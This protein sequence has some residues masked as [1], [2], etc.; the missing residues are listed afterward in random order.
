VLQQ[1][2]SSRSRL[3]WVSLS[4]TSGLRFVFPINAHRHAIMNQ[5]EAH[6]HSGC[7]VRFRP[8]LSPRPSLRS[9][10]IHTAGMHLRIT[11]LWDI[12]YLPVTIHCTTNWWLP[13][14]LGFSVQTCNK[15]QN[16][17][18]GI[19]CNESGDLMPFLTNFLHIEQYCIAL[20]L[21][22]CT[23]NERDPGSYL[24]SVLSIKHRPLNSVTWISIVCTIG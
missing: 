4:Y 10:T 9:E 8:S 23:G 22:Y 21:L 13:S 3:F 18:C 24:F 12:W 15:M 7:S 1:H 6:L 11:V 5:S 16:V 19:T 20:G 17:L 2:L 14:V